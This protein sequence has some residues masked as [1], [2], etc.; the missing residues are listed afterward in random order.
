MM[1]LL[2][3]P[4]SRPSI[5]DLH[6]PGD[7]LLH[8]ASIRLSSS[9]VSLIGSLR[10]VR[11]PDCR[12]KQLLRLLGSDPRHSG[13]GRVTRSR[14]RD[15]ITARDSYLPNCGDT[16]LRVWDRRRK[17]FDCCPG[18]AV[19]KDVLELPACL[20]AKGPPAGRPCF[21]YADA[22][23]R[24]LQHSYFGAFRSPIRH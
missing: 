12:R 20:I 8:R 15:N 21:C 1:K 24:A 2:P 4:W 11:V 16:D 3:L 7:A 17:L 18:C 23:R 6:G 10:N 9:G 13:V 22:S 19:Y 5:M 14:I